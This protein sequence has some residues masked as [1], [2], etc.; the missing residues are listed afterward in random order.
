MVADWNCQEKPTLEELI[1]LVR[2]VD[3]SLPIGPVVDGD[4]HPWTV[5]GGMRA[6]AGQ[7]IPLLVGSTT[8]EF[9]AIARSQQASL[10]GPGR[11]P[12]PRA[13]RAQP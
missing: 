7:E 3:G 8:Q 10:P 9:S 2:A 13:G 12:A 6:G 5:E 4:V 11:P 1:A